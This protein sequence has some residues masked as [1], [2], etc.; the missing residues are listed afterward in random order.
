MAELIPAPFKDLVAR[1]YREP[2]AQ[3]SLFGLP[4]KKWHVPRPGAPDLGVRFH[5]WTAGNPSGPASGPQT[6]MAQN[7][8]LSYVAGARI[9]ELKTVQ[10]NDRLTIGR[11][12]ID[13][14]NVGYNIEWSQEL[15]VEQSLRE[16][17]AGAMLVEIFRHSP[18]LADDSTRGPAGQVIYDISLGY[19]LEGIKSQ[20]VQRFL[21]GMDD[22][23]ALVQTLRSQIPPEY[24]RARD[25]DFPIHLAGSV[26]LSTFHGC[27]A[28]EIE[29]ICEFLLSDR[30]LDVIVKMNPPM[31][32]RDR[33][34]HL[35][36]EVLG[37]TELTVTPSAY[38]TGLKYDEAVE[39][40][41]RLRRFAAIRGRRFGCKFSNTLEVI[42]H[43]QFFPPGNPSQ[44]LSGQPLHVITMALTDE[45]RRAVGP[46]VP[47]SFS[48]GVDRQNFPLAV[49]CG[50]APV[51]ICTDL[52]RPGG[53]GRLPGYLQALADA[54]K[55][56]GATCLDDYIL[57]AFGQR[58]AAQARAA[59]GVSA[60]LWA[61][62][63]NTSIAAA[64]VRQDPR[65]GAAQN[66]KIP[67]RIDSRLHTFDC[68]TCDKCI[69]VCPNAAN[70]TYPTPVTAFDC[71][72]VIVDAGGSIRR[73]PGR[74]FEITRDMQ[75]A[76]YADF[77][78]ECGN[79]DT[80]CP[81]Y[82]G[83][84]IQKPGFY[85]SIESWRRAAPRDG[86][87]VENPA[88]QPAIRARIKGSEYHLLLRDRAPIYQW[89]DGSVQLTV[90]GADL[91]DL[92][93]RPLIPLNREHRMDMWIFHSVRYLLHGV[94]D[95]RW[96][97]QI[98]AG[99]PNQR[100]G[101]GAISV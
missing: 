69:P 47:I 57:D 76:N 41:A 84:Y 46:A 85:G 59:D 83:P 73:V 87:I 48:A 95:R 68:I 6:Q 26:T 77:C 29:R 9:M 67:V 90:S 1:V 2:A 12:C 14:T 75:I 88:D 25:L 37:Y 55:A 53:Y 89:S 42:N 65:Y 19:N 27:P 61:G 23:T 52:L 78:N 63:L 24:S 56:V 91:D 81:E 5:N 62:L 71:S 50:F 72:D 22:A 51:T 93:A 28:D 54:M 94:L 33:L 31:L 4:R 36:H 38:E 13:A 74:R 58:A 35:L 60:P 17:V 92:R 100:D 40:V 32:G 99:G 82:G 3:G 16:Y 64:K 101:K 43:R 45:F 79:C 96:I 34:D 86:L 98:N 97:N 10:V 66:R 18:D 15:L 20:K 70:F 7:L 39:L 49:A 44:Y 11:P 8:L 21:D 30:A 80:F